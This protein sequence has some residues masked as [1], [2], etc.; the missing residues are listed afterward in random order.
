MKQLVGS[1]WLIFLMNSVPTSLVGTERNV[2]CSV[3]ANEVMF[4]A[5]RMLLTVS[6]SVPEAAEVMQ[7]MLYSQITNQTLSYLL[8]VNILLRYAYM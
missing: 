6:D 5:W 3:E 4:Q 7:Y 8:A 2:P 1:Q